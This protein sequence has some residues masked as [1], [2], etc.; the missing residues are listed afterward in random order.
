MDHMITHTVNR[1]CKAY[2]KVATDI[3]SQLKI[4]SLVGSYPCTCHLSFSP[5]IVLSFL[6]MG[7]M[8]Q[9]ADESLSFGVLYHSVLPSELVVNKVYLSETGK[10]SDIWT[11]AELTHPISLQF[12]KPYVKFMVDKVEPVRSTTENAFDWLMVSARRLH[13]EEQQRAQP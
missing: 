9:H 10:S 3:S 8:F 7:V 12:E 13:Q 5:I 2:K 4:C 6:R 1:G 11:A